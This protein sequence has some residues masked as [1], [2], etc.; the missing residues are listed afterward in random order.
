LSLLEKQGLADRVVGV[1]LADF[2]SWPT[3]PPRLS[4]VL[5]TS[6]RAARREQP[7]DRG[8]RTRRR[9]IPARLAHFAKAMRNSGRRA[10]LRWERG[11][12]RVS[13][14]RSMAGVREPGQFSFTRQ[15]VGFAPTFAHVIDIASPFNI[16][17][18]HHV[19]SKQLI[20]LI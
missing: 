12:S 4:G 7:V 17:R 13:R 14:P 10:H 19:V 20:C 11:Q 5:R 9:G 16:C 15:K 2:R 18:A 6:D 3:R 1:K 8:G